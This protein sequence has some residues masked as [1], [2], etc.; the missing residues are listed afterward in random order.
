VSS[1]GAGS[2]GAGVGSYGLGAY[3]ASG[4]S[5]L[6]ASALGGAG[7]SLGASSLG[8]GAASSLGGAGASSMGAA[9]AYGAGGGASGFRAR[10]PVSIYSVA[11]LS[12]D[13]ASASSASDASD[14]DSS[15]CVHVTSLPSEASDEIIIKFFQDIG[16]TPLRIHRKLTGGEAF[17]EFRSP[18]D[19]GKA[20]TRNKADMVGTK[21]DLLRTSFNAMAE[22]VGLP[23]DPTQLEAAI[24]LFLS[25]QQMA[26]YGAD[27][28]S[29][30]LAAAYGLTSGSAVSS[31]SM[32]AASAASL[33]SYAFGATPYDWQ[34]QVAAAAYQQAGY[35][36]GSGVAGSSSSGLS[37][38]GVSSL[39]SAVPASA[40]GASDSA[41]SA[42][43][44]PASYGAQDYS[45]YDPAQYAQYAAQYGYGY[46]YAQAGT[47]GAFSYSS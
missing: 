11:G 46:G 37:V 24:A 22:V 26:V 30:A 38:D 16:V 14:V 31:D 4:A 10:A 5:S 34:G 40:S 7:S 3:G 8:G 23:A 42:S 2:Y 44:A 29:L 15:A 13:F 35:S 45:Q 32:S 36:L 17:I 28:Y 41:S 12:P 1:Y 6:G 33:S 18:S 20:M 25:S 9:S 39:A 21:V 43:S 47:Q 19:A 27:P